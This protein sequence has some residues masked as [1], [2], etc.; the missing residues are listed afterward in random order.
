[1]RQLPTY[2]P[3]FEPRR[4]C[5]DVHGPPLP[6]LQDKSHNYVKALHTYGM[7][8]QERAGFSSGPSIVVLMRF[9]SSER[10]LRLAATAATVTSS[11]W[12]ILAFFGS[13]QNPDFYTNFGPKK[14]DFMNFGA[15]FFIH[16]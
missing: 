6:C 3:V 13:L 12:E 15:Q 14:V 7:R 9:G 10:S 4:A 2:I 1:M 11:Q 8:R 16:F 5:A